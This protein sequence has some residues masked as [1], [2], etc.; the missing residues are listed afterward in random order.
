MQRKALREQ[1]E[2]KSSVV[3]PPCPRHTHTRSHT[4]DVDRLMFAFRW[5]RGVV[6]RMAC[7]VCLC[8]CVWMHFLYESSQ[9]V[10]KY[11]LNFLGFVFSIP[12]SFFFVVDQL[13]D[14]KKKTVEK[15]TYRSNAF[16]WFH[17]SFTKQ[18]C[19][20]LIEQ[21]YGSVY[22]HS[23]IVFDYWNRYTFE[24]NN[25]ENHIWRLGGQTFQFEN[26]NLLQF[27]MYRFIQWRNWTVA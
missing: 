27:N 8:V 2:K 20:D 26:I 6:C 18:K 7:P 9:R 17:W 22:W 13:S 19:F 24:Q 11:L 12:P 10:G 16:I 5:D 14:E 25:H 15:G 23:I 3:C 1:Q 21:F 4:Y